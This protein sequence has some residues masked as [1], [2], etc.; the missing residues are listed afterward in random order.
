MLDTT[1]SPIFIYHLKSGR[2]TPVV[3]V[4]FFIACSSEQNIVSMVS[5]YR[6]ILN[7]G[8][9]TSADEADHFN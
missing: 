4:K 6:L 1:K 8:K 5:S 2:V 7:E 3:A 9:D